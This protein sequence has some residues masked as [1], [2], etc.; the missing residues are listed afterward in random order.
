[1]IVVSALRRCLY[2]LCNLGIVCVWRMMSM[3]K[4]MSAAEVKAQTLY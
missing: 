2:G 1:M 4:M 3:M